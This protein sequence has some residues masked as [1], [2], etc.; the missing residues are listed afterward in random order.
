MVGLCTGTFAAA[1]VSC[2][3]SVT[4]LIPVAIEATVTAF[5]TGMLVED[6]A[7]RLVPSQDLNQSWAVLI[8]GAKSAALI[9][10][11]AER[12]VSRDLQD[13]LPMNSDNDEAFTTDQQAL[14][15][16]TRT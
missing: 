8:E 12:S 14:Y 9:H 16:C 7:R 13:A 2:S 11:F 1:A 3:R 4:D 15:K 6:A 10:E 5:R